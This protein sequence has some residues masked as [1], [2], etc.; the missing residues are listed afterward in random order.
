MVKEAKFKTKTM[1]TRRTPRKSE[2]SFEAKSE[3][4]ASRQASE[5][6]EKSEMPAAP[7]KE[8]F[9]TVVDRRKTE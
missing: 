3:Q 4:S 2:G 8:I 7:P 6:N 5:H 1:T 9:T